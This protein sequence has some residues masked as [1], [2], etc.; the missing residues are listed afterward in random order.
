MC[1]AMYVYMRSVVLS[2]ESGSQILQTY[3]KYPSLE[4]GQYLEELISLAWSL[5]EALRN[6]NEQ[7]S[8]GNWMD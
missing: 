1:V 8:K 2:L 4:K 7:N 6:S 5:C 3:Q